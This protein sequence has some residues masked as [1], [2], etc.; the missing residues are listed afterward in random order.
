MTGHRASG[1]LTDEQVRDLLA[2]GE[3][4]DDMV[5]RIVAALRQAGARV[6]L[7]DAGGLDSEQALVVAVVDGHRMRITAQPW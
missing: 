6:D 4:G 7:E 3:P 2:P 1:T 5:L